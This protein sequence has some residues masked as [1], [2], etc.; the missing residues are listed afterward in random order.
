MVKIHPVSGVDLTC[1]ET[2]FLKGTKNSLL[3]EMFD[4]G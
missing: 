2:T 4:E 1:D 3:V